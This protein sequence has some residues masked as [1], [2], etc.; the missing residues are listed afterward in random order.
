MT[1]GFNQK[2]AN[3]YKDYMNMSFSS[4]HHEDILYLYSFIIVNFIHYFSSE[5]EILPSMS[6]YHIRHCLQLYVVPIYHESSGSFVHKICF[7]WHLV[8]GVAASMANIN[9]VRD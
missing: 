2:M 9:L 6:T 3:S 5:S 7:G 4:A 1:D 8:W